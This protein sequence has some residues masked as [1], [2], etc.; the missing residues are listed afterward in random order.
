MM[1]KQHNA[2]P[3]VFLNIPRWLPWLYPFEKRKTSNV[4][5][6]HVVQNFDVPFYQKKAKDT[7]LKFV[8]VLR[9]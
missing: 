5:G 1:E 3:S 8:C 9:V 4:S 7:V 2:I 6:L